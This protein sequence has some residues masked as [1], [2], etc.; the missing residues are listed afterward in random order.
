VPEDDTRPDR[1]LEEPLEGGPVAGARLTRGRLSEMIRGYNE[2]RGWSPEGYP[3]A[4]ATK[5]LLLDV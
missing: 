5:E 3:S 1:F 2:A 4:A